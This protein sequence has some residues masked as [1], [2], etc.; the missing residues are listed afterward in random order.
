M[1]SKHTKGKTFIV[2]GDKSITI[3]ELI[4]TIKKE[5][6]INTIGI[7][8]LPFSKLDNNYSI[9]SYSN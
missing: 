7:S 6:N 4:E 1:E 5:L 2:A 3:D 8:I 9:D